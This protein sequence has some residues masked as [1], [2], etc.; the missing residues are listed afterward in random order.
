MA[1]AGVKEILR[2]FLVHS[3][4]VIGTKHGPVGERAADHFIPGRRVV[5]TL[6]EVV[7]ERLDVAYVVERLDGGDDFAPLERACQRLNIRLGLRAVETNSNNVIAIVI[8][9][10]PRRQLR[11][12]SIVCVAGGATGRS[13]RTRQH[14]TQTSGAAMAFQRSAPGGGGRGREP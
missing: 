11:Q 12:C 8:D 5:H 10:P 6:D 3:D 13:W 1:E 9:R 7:E 14:P 4:V 2:H